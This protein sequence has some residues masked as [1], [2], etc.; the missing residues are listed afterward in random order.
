MSSKTLANQFRSTYVYGTFNN[1]DNASNNI[2]ARAAFQRDVLIGTNLFLGK[3]EKDD[4]GDFLDSTANIQFTLNKQIVSF[5]V[6]TL[7]FI[8]NVTSDVQQQIQ[9]LSNNINN[10]EQSLSFNDLTISGTLNGLKIKD[11][12]NSN[13]SFSTGNTDIL[14]NNNTRFGYYTGLLSG[15]SNAVFG[16]QSLQ[17]CTGHSNT[18][19]GHNSQNSNTSYNWNTSLGSN[20]N[21]SGGHSNIAIGHVAQC[22][23][24]TN[25]IVIGNSITC[26]TN[27]EILLGSSVHTTLIPGSL[28][29]LGKISQ[30]IGNQNTAFGLYSFSSNTSGGYNTVFGYNSL[31]SN[32]GGAYCT[33]IGCN[34]LQSSNAFGNTAIGYN[35]GIDVA[36]GTYNT[37]LGHNANASQVV[38]NSTAIGNNATCNA[39]NQIMV[40]TASENVVIPGNLTISQN[41]NGISSTT[42][43]YLSGVTSSIQTQISNANTAI[44]NVAFKI[45]DISWSIGL[46]NKTT[47]A[48]A[49]STSVLTFSNTLN[50]VS[51]TTFSYLSGVSSGIQDQLNAASTA[52]AALNTKTIDILWTPGQIN[53][54]TI[55]NH[56]ETDTL[57]FSNSLNSI[58][59][60]T[61]GYLSGVTSSIQT[62]INALSTLPGTVIAFAGSASFLNGYLLC[63]GSIY[64]SQNYNALFNA[65]GTI[66][67]DA[68]NGNFCV[69]NY[70]GI[71]L[72]GT[73]SQDVRL[74]VIAGS[75]GAFFK[76]FSSPDLGQA[77]PDQSAY[78]STGNYVDQISTQTRTVVTGSPSLLGN[79]STA[80][81]ISSVNYTTTN[82]SYNV[83]NPDV[84]PA[85]ASVQY[86]IKY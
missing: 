68:G 67:G 6:T 62:Q 78:F 70:Q 13:T 52:I 60:T 43:G 65:I 80:N 11:Y 14:G 33:A 2:Q 72:R 61:F 35:A 53:K 8:K 7:Q 21:I 47:I 66:Y 56:C 28:N 42:F 81:V 50:S 64:N 36:T 44:S 75:G 9:D 18:A 26:T 19:I 40:G 31:T 86:F 74:N 32:T 71:F 63:D 77:V 20:S 49:C 12:G 29:I 38:A 46:P 27:N 57:T 45:S 15:Y 59:T 48:N 84:H 34:A 24:C 82:N 22:S 1:M 4:S 23:N 51:T 55:K 76:N 58:S 73:G 69:P 30:N 39:S 3:G 25:S 10:G 37:F 83:G 54:T 17:Y 85:H 5:P 16:D 41:L 79:Y